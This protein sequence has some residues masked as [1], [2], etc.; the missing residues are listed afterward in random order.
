MKSLKNNVYFKMATIIIVALILLIPTAMVSGLIDDREHNRHKAINEVTQMWANGQTITGPFLTIPYYEIIKRTEKGQEIEHKELNYLHILPE[1]LEMDG[2]IVPQ[3]RKRGIYEVV[4]YE[5]KMALSGSFNPILNETIGIDTSLILL[6]Q[7]T[8]N[9]GVSDLRGVEKQIQLKW[10]QDESLFESGTMTRDVVESGV[11]TKVK[12]PHLN[13]A[14][15]FQMEVDLKGSEYFD[16]LPLGKT[17]TVDLH[18][19]WTTPS[20]SGNFIP[21]TSEVNDKGFNAH[22]NIL[23]LNRNYPQ[24]WSNNSHQISYSAFG[25][26]LLLPVDNYKRSD[27]VVKYSVLFIALTFV[28]FFFME[29]MSKLFIHPIQY[30][31]VGT[32]LVIFF[33][34]LISISEHLMFNLAYSISALLT[35]GLITLYS[36]S[37]LKSTKKALVLLGLLGGMYAFIFVI[38]Q[39]EDMALLM[40]SIG[41]FV[42]L[43]IVMY[44]SRQIDWYQLKLGKEE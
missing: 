15:S 4:V 19:D 42:I 20:F 2:E 37:I 21:D 23:N 22:W 16:M 33:T 27:R 43:S 14:F 17:T 7:A 41:L 44:I 6:D 24:S 28:I 36:R 13:Q 29:I 40:G 8:I 12:I 25:L 10:G 18:S 30:L 26:N 1:S 38:I 3:I 32:A 39:L 31:L 34:L 35:L 9:M 11:H 5:S